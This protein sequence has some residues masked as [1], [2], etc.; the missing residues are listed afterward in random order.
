MNFKKKMQLILS[1][2]FAASTLN[3]P[4]VQAAEITTKR[5]EGANRYETAA[6]VCEEGWNENSDW[7]VI[8]NGENFADALSAAPLAK[9]NNA[10][11]LLTN[12]KVLNIYTSMQINRLK[13]KNV[14]LIGGKGVISQNVEDGIKARGIKVTRLGGKDRYETALLVAGKVGK[15]KQIAV[16][17]G[18]DFHDAVSIA[19]IAALKG[20]PIV[21]VNKNYI[22]PSVVKYLSSNKKV[23]QTYVIGGEDQISSK[24]FKGIPNALRIGSGDY[25]KRN[26]DVINAFQNE[27]D[28]S[29][30][31][32]ASGRDFA[33]AL[34]A[35]AIAPK[36]SSPIVFVG[37]SLNSYTKNFIQGKIINDIGILGGTASVSY[38]METTMKYLPLEVSDTN[39]IKKD[40]YQNEAFNP[41]STIV[42]TASDGS[43]KEVQVTWNLTRVDTTKPG[44]YNFIGSIDG[45]DKKVNLT[46]VVKP[47]PDKIE[48]IVAEA[49]SRYSYNLPKT[50]SAKMTD[51]SISSVSVVWDYGTQQK[52]KPG[53]YVF[54]GTVEHY[55]KKVKLTLNVTNKPSNQIIK[56]IN[57]IKVIV[58]R[59]SDFNLPSTVVATME[60]NSKKDVRVTWGSEKK[61]PNYEGVYTYEGIVSGY[62]G[63]VRLML[64]VTGEN[65]VDPNDP[66][67]P[68][69]PVDPN[70]PDNP[71]ENIKDLGELGAIMQGEAYPTTVIDPSTNKPVQ[72][73]WTRAV[74]INTD[75]ID[76]EYIDDCRVSKVT[77]EGTIGGANGK[78]VKATIGI[79][80]KI[81][82][83]TTENNYPN[84]V[85]IVIPVNSNG[86]Y[87]MSQ[88]SEKL[89]AV[90]IGSDGHTRTAKKVKVLL[91]DP[92]YIDVGD[93]QNYYVRATI[94]HYN[95]P[96]MVTLKIQR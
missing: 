34:S 77:L 23:E 2:V 84:I 59:K 4:K 89:R 5:F 36:T 57:N 38:G 10:P 26:I 62:S 48:D 1:I 12:G 63:K 86:V 81:I 3:V 79:I 74:N 20:M 92:P 69:D 35:S 15:P 6:K 51:G 8:V 67:Y 58:Q 90:I 42:V 32:I 37:S 43:K 68:V 80:P 53:T 94:S 49:E 54:Y 52:S 76:A 55:K 96:V 85:P 25:Y 39:N 73:S 29:T 16:V 78:K 47:I 64:I 18:N 88:A 61:Y 95:T 71:D 19:P 45:Y 14:Y 13:V 83:I 7:A 70:N 27:L 31:Y 24:V 21:L 40:I 65:G 87:D 60:D 9:K 44:V 22:P 66:N 56:T 11:I 72:V 50:V 91:W 30:V 82:G 17:N 93:S 41:P 33:D 46:L 28:F 75:F